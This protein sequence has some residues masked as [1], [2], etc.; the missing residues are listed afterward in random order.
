VVGGK[1]QKSQHLHFA[2]R[3][4]RHVVWRLAP[5]VVVVLV[6]LVIAGVIK[7]AAAGDPNLS[8]RPV[9]PAT[10]T[11]PGPAPKPAGPAS[12]EAA[13]EVQGLPPLGS[14]GPDSPVPIASLAKVMTAY[15][16]LQA[17][18]IKPGQDGFTITVGA[19]D[20]ADYQTRLAGSESVVAVS[21]GE[22]LS[23]AELL[24]GLLVA[25][26]NNFAVI[27]AQHEAGSVN[28]FIAKMN[29]T[30]AALGMTHTRYTDP[31]GL[32]TSTMS[33]A[34]DQLVL[35]AHAMAE[36]AFA[37]IVAQTSVTLPV[38]GTAPNFN[39]AVGHDGFVGI[40]TGSETE[41]GGCLMFANHQVRGGHTVTILGVVLGQHTGSVSTTSLVAAAVSAANA[42]V[43]SVTAG[44]ESTTILAA[45]TTVAKVSS[46][47]GRTVDVDT[48]G[49]LSVM[50]Y[51]GT[52][53]PLSVSLDKVA[54][55]VR[56][57]QVVA[58]VSIEGSPG[59]DATVQSALSGASFGWKLR[60]DY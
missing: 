14:S 18:P 44:V 31:S 56:T 13:V 11:I 60:H 15:I 33:T 1:T 6:L 24:Q 30:A 22:T 59:V 42:L 29:T 47:D 27:L 35:A 2:P 20:V 41:S 40:K 17:H 8:I 55:G 9:L 3:K 21:E 10:V 38:E 12:G 19:P 16:V 43:H 57:G 48:T 39:T 36:P 34:S 26:G 58:H 52:A 37:Q 54:T 45:G 4:R 7:A 51:G 53:V 23:E 49:P 32:H 5:V 50:G 25:S 28:A 46:A